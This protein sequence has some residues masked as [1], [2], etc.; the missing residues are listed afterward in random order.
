MLLYALGTALRVLSIPVGIIIWTTIFVFCLNWQVNA[1]ERRGFSRLVSTALAYVGLAVFVLVLGGIMFSPLFG[2]GNQFESLVLGIPVFFEQMSN[3]ITEFYAEYGHLTDNAT[4]NTVLQS[5]QVSA[6]DWLKGLASTG[7]ENLMD[8][9]SVTANSLLCIGFAL[10]VAFWLLLEMP[11]IEREIYR[12]MRGKH[13]EDFQFFRVTM[14]R[15]LGGYIK[16]TLLQCGIIALGC[17]I[18]FSILGVPNPVA[19]GIVTGLFNVIP[20]VG[21]WFGGAV[22]GLAAIFESPIIALLALVVTV[23][24]Q[25]VVY[26]FISP[27]LMGDSVDVHPALVILAMMIGYALGNQLSGVMG[28]LVGMLLSI[29]LA[30]MAKA[31]FVYYFEKSTGRQILSEDGVIFKGTPL[32]KP[33]RTLREDVPQGQ[34]RDSA[35]AGRGLLQSV[36]NG[37][38]GSE[39]SDGGASL[40]ASGKT[41]SRRADSTAPRQARSTAPPRRTDSASEPP[42]RRGSDDQARQDYGQDE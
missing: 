27:K 17:V 11:A 14:A 42:A 9:G 7:V 29:P 10:V 8:I 2:I 35:P 26:T 1:L 33:S 16:A 23:I 3:G 19:I 39:A 31:T 37:S 21:A 25:Q 36:R 6:T 12:L 32:R 15:A 28:S 20:V 41:S 34:R 13:S 38:R 4:A 40:R 22:A 24:I 5:L 18:A 30:A